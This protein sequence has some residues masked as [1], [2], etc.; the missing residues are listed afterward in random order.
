[1]SNAKGT[2]E[3]ALGAAETV[4]PGQAKL[5]VLGAA[6]TVPAAI[7]PPLGA[8]TLPGGVDETLPGGAATVPGSGARESF[9]TDATRPA[10]LDAA[11]THLP[12]AD[13]ATY[14]LRE[15]L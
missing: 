9:G 6:G 4:A 11:P 12:E 7:N 2:D 15:E 13:R 8:A 5:D 14:E 1:M 10:G 3:T